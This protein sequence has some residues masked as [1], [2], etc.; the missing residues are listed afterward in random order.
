MVLNFR[1]ILAKH[2]NKKRTNEL[3]SMM[4]RF[5]SSDID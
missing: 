4:S 2:I 5:S 3:Q 1:E